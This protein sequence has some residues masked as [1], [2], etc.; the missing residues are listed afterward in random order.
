M[1]ATRIFCDLSLCLLSLTDVFS[2]YHGSLI[3][4]MAQILSLLCK[5]IHRQ[6]SLATTEKVQNATK[7]DRARKAVSGL[8]RHPSMRTHQKHLGRHLTPLGRDDGTGRVHVGG[9]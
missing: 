8:S 7:Y 5:L 4:Q 3:P 2:H 1:A 6:H 9:R